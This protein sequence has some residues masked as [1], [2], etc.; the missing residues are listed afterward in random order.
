LKNFFFSFKGF[1]WELKNLNLLQFSHFNFF[2][3]ILN[4]KFL[5]LHLFYSINLIPQTFTNPFLFNFNSQTENWTVKNIFSQN[6]IALVVHGSVS[7]SSCFY[8][9]AHTS[10][11]VKATKKCLLAS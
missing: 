8:R 7:A 10:D 5:P 4:S 3:M 6:L 1:L 11:L 9:S 2:K